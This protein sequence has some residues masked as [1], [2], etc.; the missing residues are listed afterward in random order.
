MKKQAT[1]FAA[2]ALIFGPIVGLMLGLLFS[3]MKPKDKNSEDTIK[4]D[5]EE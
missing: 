2:F 4:K 5:N 3:K 1:N